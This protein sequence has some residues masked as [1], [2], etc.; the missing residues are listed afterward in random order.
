MISILKY[1]REHEPNIFRL[2]ANKTCG[3]AYDLSTLYFK[4]MT[5]RILWEGLH[6]IMDLSLQKGLVRTFL[7][8]GIE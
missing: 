5:F 1:E 2:E 8:V 3:V 7:L 4:L 6:K